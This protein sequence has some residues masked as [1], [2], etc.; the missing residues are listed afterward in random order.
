MREIPM[1]KIIVNVTV[2]VLL[3]G[4]VGARAANL[5]VEGGQLIGAENVL[6]GGVSYDVSFQVAECLEI[7]NTCDE[8]EFIFTTRESAT[9]AGY[10][11]M[12]QVLIDDPLGDFDTQPELTVGCDGRTSCRIFTPYSIPFDGEVDVIVVENVEGPRKFR[13]VQAESHYNENT[14]IYAVWFVTND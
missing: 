13:R 6:V 10:A 9:W 7:F 2:L 8:N 5:I 12:N 4:P 3:M 1:R 11:L 14:Y